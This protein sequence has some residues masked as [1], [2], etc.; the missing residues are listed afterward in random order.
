MESQFD[1]VIIGGG[2]SGCC[3]AMFTAALLPYVRIAIIEGTSRE[4]GSFKVGES[5]ASSSKTYLHQLGV[6]NRIEEEI[7]QG[8]INKCFGNQSCW[9]SDELHG[10]DF[11]AS[12]YGD[13]FHLDRVLFEK[14]LADAAKERKNITWIPKKAEKL[15]RIDGS[16][17]K[18]KIQC[19]DSSEV[20]SSI[21]V[22]AS[23]RLCMIQKCLGKEQMERI[24]LDKMISFMG[25]FSMEENAK[26]DDFHYS[27]VEATEDGWFYSSLL[28][29]KKRIIIFHTDDDLPI[30]RR[31]RK[32]EVFLSMLEK[33]KHLNK[34]T[35]NY[36]LQND[37]IMVTSANSAISSKI[38]SAKDQW[39]VVGDSAMSFDPLSSQGMITSI[40]CS[41]MISHVLKSF[42]TPDKKKTFDEMVVLYERGICN[43]FRDFL[44]HRDY[45]Y[46]VEKRFKENEF[47]K[48]RQT[49]E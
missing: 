38:G 35:K 45:F 31:C 22:D 21:L 11:M 12:A 26:E 15:T 17:S 47:W 16:D 33:T 7:K 46:G 20:L 40:Q 27:V 48:R 41:G 6:L 43:I 37:R 18:W 24:N 32:T 28:P 10:I 19:A 8:N 1:I 39:L 42:Y 23:G 30:A 29:S 2:I 44:V 34:I 9:G 5:L 25:L 4:P 49:K 14:I 36:Q 3:T 13:G